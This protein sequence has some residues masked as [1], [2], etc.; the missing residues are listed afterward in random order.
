[1]TNTPVLR[2]RKILIIGMEKQTAVAGVW[3]R[4]RRINIGNVFPI[5]KKW[6]HTL[7]GDYA[8]LLGRYESYV[9]F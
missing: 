1:M 7:N 6:P 5:S 3:L 9:D 8:D 4:F 2:G